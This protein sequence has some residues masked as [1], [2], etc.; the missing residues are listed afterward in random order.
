MSSLRCRK[1]GSRID[2]S[3]T[4]SPVH[5]ASGAVVGGSVL[6][7]DISEAKRTEQELRES[8]ERLSVAVQA[9]D[10]GLFRWECATNRVIWDDTLRALFGIE[11][12]HG[13]A[14]RG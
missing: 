4:I 13:G 14:W 11:D 2:V 7:R 8:R 10:I 1:D 12:G 5:D 3:L 9:A 6:A